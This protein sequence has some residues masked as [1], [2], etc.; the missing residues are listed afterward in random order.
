M[1][2]CRYSSRTDPGYKKVGGELARLAQPGRPTQNKSY[3]C[4]KTPGCSCLRHDTSLGNVE[5]TRQMFDQH[6]NCCSV[7]GCKKALKFE[8]MLYRQNVIRAPLTNTCQWIFDHETYLSWARRQDIEISRSMMWIKGVPGSGKSTIVKEIVRKTRL[9]AAYTHLVIGF[10]FNARGSELEHT[11]PGMLRSILLQL[12]NYGEDVF[13]HVILSHYKESQ[14]VGDQEWT[15]QLEEL[16]QLL[17]KCLVDVEYKTR[18][19]IFVDALD[20]C[21]ELYARQIACFFRDLTDAAFNSGRM[22][23]LCISCRHYPHI[24]FPHCPAISVEQANRDDIFTFIKTRIPYGIV[25]DNATIDEL[26][27]I[28]ANKSNGIFLWVVLVVSMVIRDIDSGCSGLE[29]QTTIAKVPSDLEAIFKSLLQSI[30]EN[31][32]PRFQQLIYWV[33]LGQERL[34]GGVALSIDWLGSNEFHLLPAC[35]STR[36][37][38]NVLP[39]LT[40]RKDRSQKLVRSLSRGLVEE[41]GNCV[42]FIHETVREFFL[43]NGYRIL[44]YKS[45]EAFLALGHCIIIRSCI[46]AMVLFDSKGLRKA[47]LKWMC[48]YAIRNMRDHAII[49]LQYE[50]FPVAVFYLAGWVVRENGFIRS[51]I[52]RTVLPDWNSLGYDGQDK[53]TKDYMAEIFSKLDNCCSASIR[54][55]QYDYMP[56]HEHMSKT[57]KPNVYQQLRY[58][59]YKLLKCNQYDSTARSYDMGVTGSEHIDMTQED[60]AI[61]RQLPV[62]MDDILQGVS[63]VPSASYDG[64]SK[65]FN[66]NKL[67][68]LAASNGLERLVRHLIHK[69]ASVHYR[70]SLGMTALHIACQFNEVEIVRLLLKNKSNPAEKGLCGYTPLHIAVENGNLKMVE[71]LLKAM[72]KEDMNVKNSYGQTATHLAARYL[73]NVDM[74]KLLL[75]SGADWTIA[76]DDGNL[77]YHIACKYSNYHVADLLDLQVV[78]PWELLWLLRDDDDD[79]GI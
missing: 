27:S 33:L 73:G 13:G 63:Q 54:N 29:I 11:Q 35:Y 12:L 40:Y 66:N 69:G 75:Q 79:V 67:L 42:E 19:T 25:A 52:T 21:G 51:V 28:I 46:R 38:S 30:S 49:A 72:S 17:R 45:A 15:P 18:V 64:Y 2:M 65:Y 47:S 59:P 44:G 70:N 16:Q 78:L 14:Q 76:D 24:T 36:T 48:Q 7:E 1:D 62:S 20:E 31:E 57:I 6:S 53:L 23:D 34:S 58:L 68:H 4:L 3:T 60:V 43:Q 5:P 71:L 55:P 50:V 32:I 22:L 37:D 77:P 61:L 26:R 10:Y 41:V 8:G 39:G 74:I 9:E 56:Q